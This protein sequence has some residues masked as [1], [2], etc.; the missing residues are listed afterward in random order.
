[1]HHPDALPQGDARRW[2]AR[3]RCLVGMKSPAEAGQGLYQSQPLAPASLSGLSLLAVVGNAAT[4]QKHP[5]LLECVE[6]LFERVEQ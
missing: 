3:H 4:E 6:A 1:M 5:V 2:P